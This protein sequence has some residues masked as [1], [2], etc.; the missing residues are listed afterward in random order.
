MYFL[1]N[2]LKIDKVAT[3]RKYEAWEGHWCFEPVDQSE[4]NLLTTLDYFCWKPR[5]GNK[6]SIRIELSDGTVEVPSKKQ[7]DTY[8]FV[9]KNQER[10]LVGV[11][12]YY[13]NLVLPVYKAAIDIDEN[14]IANSK[15]E[16]SKVF[17][18]K[19]IEIPPV[20]EYHSMYFMI[21]F[22]FRYDCE[23]G[24]CLLFKDD[25]PIDLF[26]EGEK[27]YDAI[28]IYQHGLY[29]KDDSPLEIHVTRLNGDSLLKG[30]YYFNE[31]I[32][33]DLPR[34]AYRIFYTVNKSKRVRN[35]IVKEDKRYFTL[36]YVLR[37]C[38][39]E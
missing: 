39:V 14:L 27:D 4:L 32:K 11:W 33:F 1:R 16:L 20:E 12:D 26:S 31:E 6:V 30:K 36:E 5:E 34:G 37:N 10:I 21:E 17:G 7:I 35:F 3:Y 13:I 9:I 24:L 19:S 15:S 22:D 25:I 8:E 18:I 38:E 2:S 29:N 23:H 28:T